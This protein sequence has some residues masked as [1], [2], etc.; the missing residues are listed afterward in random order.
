MP[1]LQP[2]PEGWRFW[3]PNP[4]WYRRFGPNY[5]GSASWTRSAGLLGMMSIAIVVVSIFL[6]PSTGPAIVAALVALAAVG[7]LIPREILRRRV[8]RSGMEYLRGI[9]ATGRREHLI[10][11]YQ[12]YLRDAG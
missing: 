11:L 9:A 7:C 4:E 5:R 8:T 2:A 10:R 1:D 3:R 6:P 12:S